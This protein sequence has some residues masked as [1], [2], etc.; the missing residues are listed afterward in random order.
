MR[1]FLVCVIRDN[2]WTELKKYPVLSREEESS[3]VARVRTGDAYARDVLIKSNLRLVN[4][5]ARKYGR[6]SN[7]DDCVQ[8]ASIGLIQAVDAIKT[9]YDPTR[10]NRF[11]SYAVRSM[12]FRV[13][14][15]LDRNNTVVCTRN[16]VPL[17]I[18][19]L[20]ETMR[21][22]SEATRYDFIVG[23]TGESIVQTLYDAD[24]YAA[25]EDCIKRAPF[26]EK[27][28]EILDRTLR[29]GQTPK[30]ICNEIHWPRRRV[31]YYINKGMRYI[32]NDFKR[33]PRLRDAFPARNSSV[34][35][36]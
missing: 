17:D 29:L 9:T 11:T 6:Y 19:S 12:I 18:E 1:W 23:D 25:V 21:T 20:D 22:D 30:E 27:T 33:D 10:G 5:I 36:P 4:L 13:Q 16:E 7:L 31:I 8:E 24:A 26:D 15:F 28:K 3:M 32:R 2:Y 34:R 35:K 14:D